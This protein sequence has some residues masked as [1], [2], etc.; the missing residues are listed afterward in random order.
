MKKSF[1]L[2]RTFFE[3]NYLQLRV[4]DRVKEGLDLQFVCLIVHREREKVNFVILKKTYVEKL[5]FLDR[6]SISTILKT[7]FKTIFPRI[8]SVCV[9]VIQIH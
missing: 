9:C 3:N 8:S 1:S 7:R 5:S 4:Q 6:N 2:L